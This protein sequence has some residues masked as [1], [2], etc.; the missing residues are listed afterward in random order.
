MA[1]AARTPDLVRVLPQTID[2]KLDMWLAMHED[3]KT[4]RRVRLV[5]DH[6]AEGLSRYVRQQ[7]D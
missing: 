2:F 1:V 4:T 6:L 5:F 7:A 3:M